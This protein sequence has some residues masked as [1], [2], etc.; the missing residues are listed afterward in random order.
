MAAALEAFLFFLVELV[1]SSKTLKLV[2][3]S[4]SSIKFRIVYTGTP[5]HEQWSTYKCH[6]MNYFQWPKSTTL[7]A[8]FSIG[9]YVTYSQPELLQWPWCGGCIYGGLSHTFNLVTWF[10]GEGNLMGLCPTSSVVTKWED[11][12]ILKGITLHLKVR[13]G[14]FLSGSADGGVTQTL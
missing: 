1:I 12:S 14:N 10:D 4:L 7:Q 6:R 9:T 5:L 11:S 8:R 2:S 3:Q 13:S